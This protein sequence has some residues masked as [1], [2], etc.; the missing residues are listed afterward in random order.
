VKL[1]FHP[2]GYRVH[3]VLH[4]SGFAPKLLGASQKPEI[5]TDAIVM[6]YL[7]PPTNLKDGWKTLHDLYLDAPHL[8]TSEKPAIEEV[9]NNLVHI[10]EENQL[11]H[12]D[13]RSNNLLIYVTANSQAIVKPVRINAIDMEWAGAVGEAFYPPNRNENVGFPGVAGGLIGAHHDN[14]MIKIL[15]T[16]IL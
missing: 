3:E 16:S 15:L 11:V 2:Y 7:A 13:L 4:T 5:C 10:L 9:L 1:A 12:G 6:E 14:F 8:L